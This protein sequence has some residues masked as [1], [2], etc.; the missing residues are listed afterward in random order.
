LEKINCTQARTSKDYMFNIKAEKAG[1]RLVIIAR[2][3]S[4]LIRIPASQAIR[5]TTNN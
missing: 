1:N 5:P 3:N 2:R 4:F